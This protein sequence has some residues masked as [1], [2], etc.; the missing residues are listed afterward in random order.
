MLAPSYEKASKDIMKKVFNTIDAVVDGAS[1]KDNVI[2]V[3]VP[4]AGVFVINRQPP[5]REI[6]LSSPLTGPYHFKSI[7]N[8]WIDSRGRDLLS[9]ISKEILNSEHTLE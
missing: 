4:G 1:I 9:I 2:S 6:W 7:Q 5:K 3:E 8:K